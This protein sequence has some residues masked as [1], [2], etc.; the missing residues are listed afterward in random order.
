M[1]ATPLILLCAALGLAGASAIAQSPAKPVDEPPSSW[2]PMIPTPEKF[3]WIQLTSG[4]WLKGELLSLYDDTL[5]F[6]SKELDELSFDLEDINQIRTAR[7]MRVAFAHH[8]KATGRIVLKGQTVQI[9]GEQPGAEILEY[10]LADIISIAPGRPK[11]RNN[12][13]FRFGLG[14]NVR[15]GNSEQLELNGNLKIQRRTTKNRITLDYIGNYNLTDDVLITDN[16]RATTG[17]NYYVSRNLFVVPIFLEY[18]SDP[19]QNVGSRVTVGAGA[20]YRVINTKK[21]DMQISTGPG[22]Q[23]T[24]FADVGESEDDSERTPAWT[25]T[26]EFDTKVAKW[27]DFDWEYRFQITNEKSGTYNHHMVVGFNIDITKRLDFDISVVWDRIR[28][29]RPDSDDVVP[30]QDDLR[31]IVGL[32]LDF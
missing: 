26:V 3:D 6:D 24:V 5:E 18:F 21:T 15:R 20:G 17:W 2:L 4:E 23:E 9:I 16:H 7:I 11:E 1:R 12:W 25:T 8:V 19:F 27:M 28:D 14:G 32:A 29:P 30:E 13:V 22:I 10:P 31:L